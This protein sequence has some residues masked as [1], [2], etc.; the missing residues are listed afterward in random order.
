LLTFKVAATY[1][2]VHDSTKKKDSKGEMLSQN[3][4]RGKKEGKE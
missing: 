4:K 1:T 3:M 2:G